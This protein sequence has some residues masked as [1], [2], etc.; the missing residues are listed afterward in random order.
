[1]YIFYIFLVCYYEYYDHL[2]KCTSIFS[3]LENAQFLQLL[4]IL[5]MHEIDTS[6]WL[7][8]DINPQEKILYKMIAD[9]PKSWDI[10][11][12][13]MYQ[14]SFKAREDKDDCTIG[15]RDITH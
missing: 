6:F 5:V 4:D 3:L 2:A 11:D 8:V 1:M 7:I 9:I 10:A 15:M 14:F 13:L 12:A